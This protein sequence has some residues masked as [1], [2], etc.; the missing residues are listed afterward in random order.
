MHA[1]ATGS[2]PKGARA[3]ALKGTSYGHVIAPLWHKA[4][5]WLE[6]EKGVLS[7]LRANLDPQASA[8]GPVLRTR[9]ISAREIATMCG[10]DVSKRTVQRTLAVLRDEQKAGVLTPHHERKPG[11]REQEPP[12]YEIHL[13]RLVELER[14]E[15]PASWPRGGASDAKVDDVASVGAYAARVEA[16]RVAAGLPEYHPSAAKLARRAAVADLRLMRL[17]RAREALAKREERLARELA[18]LEAELGK[19]QGG[20]APSPPSPG[21]ANAWGSDTL[22]LPSPG[23]A[24]VRGSDTPPPPSPSGANAWGS[25]T[26]SLPPAVDPDDELAGL[27]AKHAEVQARGGAPARVIQLPSL[28]AARA[29]NSSAGSATDRAA[30]ASNDEGDALQA[31]ALTP[32]EREFNRHVLFLLYRYPMLGPI[33]NRRDAALIGASARR[34][35]RL[36]EQ[37][38]EAL[39]RLVY[40]LDRGKYPGATT[41]D[42]LLRLARAF[43]RDQ[44]PTRFDEL[45][46]NV[47][48]QLG[49]PPPPEPTADELAELRARL[50]LSEEQLA[51]LRAEHEEREEVREHLEEALEQLRARYTFGVIE[52]WFGGVQY[53]GPAGDKVR[54]R[55]ANAFLRDWIERNYG[56]VL[57]ETLRARTGRPFSIAWTIDPHLDEPLTS[58]LPPVPKRLR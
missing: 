7:V 53:D 20:D 26:P 21:G 11:S 16:A 1:E 24:H 30:E 15:R 17:T 29:A 51:E 43:A 37:V 28:V 45:P 10:L 44:W 50:G 23:G 5:P 39:D 14:I 58:G 42:D 41:H 19:M 54:L 2:E 3:K 47:L 32:E 12:W 4:R 48:H 18:E 13:D 22:S 57:I 9:R 49:P 8:E 36:P 40:K 31:H 55:A 33:A 27:R 52:Q 34:R 35:K 38:E 6:N 25:D 46:T 56:P